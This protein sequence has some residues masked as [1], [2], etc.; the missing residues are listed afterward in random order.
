[1]AATVIVSAIAMGWSGEDDVGLKAAAEVAA[2]LR[3]RAAGR[4]AAAA[5]GMIAGGA[6]M[7]GVERRRYDPGNDGT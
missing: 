7:P 4:R 6:D 5:K 3:W 2:M 1:M